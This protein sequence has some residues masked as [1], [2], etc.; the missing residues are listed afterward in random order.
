[1]V[2]ERNDRERRVSPE[3]GRRSVAL[4]EALRAP[5]DAE[6]ARGRH[7]AEQGGRRDDRGAREVPE[8]ADAHAV[9]PVAVE[10]GDRALAFPQGVGALTETRPAPGLPDLG[11]G[12][13]EDVGDRLAAE[14][15]IGLL[16]IALHA[17]RAGED[18]ELLDRAGRSLR[19]RRAQNEGR[20][21]QIAVSTVRARA[22]ERLVE[23]EPLPRDLRRRER[24]R[25]TERLRD[26][27][28]DLGKVERLVDL[29]SRL[30]AWRE[31]RV[32]KV[33]G[34]LLAIP[35]VGE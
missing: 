5:L 21:E 20:L 12:S 11:A 10:G 15:G 34:A 16:D 8:A 23:A 33:R 13:A 14:S 7:V 28:D 19:A 3:W 18:D 35:R 4:D 9:C 25:R 26:E 27:R 6:L 31:S 2:G 22:D 24:V 17:A 1:M 30:R 29:V 32:G